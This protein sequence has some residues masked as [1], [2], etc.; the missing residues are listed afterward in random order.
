MNKF[1]IYTIISCAFTVTNVHAWDFSKIKI[2]A[3]EHF[4]WHSIEVSKKQET[5]FGLSNTINIG[6]EIPFE[7]YYGLSFSPILGSAESKDSN[8][9]DIG[10]DIQLLSVGGEFKHFPTK[11][12]PSLFIRNGI[13]FN[14][15][16][17]NG[18]IKTSDGCFLYSGVGWETKI[19]TFGLAIELAGRVSKMKNDIFIKS[20]TPSIG[21]HFYGQ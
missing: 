6:R 1:F 14:Q 3:R 16:T 9:Q 18:D 4:E 10:T 5:Y 2:R 8:L 11:N 17:T 15:L 21:L 20:F 7:S 19:K 13:G 12:Y